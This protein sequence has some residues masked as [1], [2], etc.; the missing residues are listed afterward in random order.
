MSIDEIKQQM[1]AAADELDRKDRQIDEL[2]ELVEQ[3][4]AVIEETCKRY[5]NALADQQ[6]YYEREILELRLRLEDS[7]CAV[8]AFISAI[9]DALQSDPTLN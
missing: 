5:D 3:Q 2:L 1:L 8:A 6:A 4:E 7:E 9:P